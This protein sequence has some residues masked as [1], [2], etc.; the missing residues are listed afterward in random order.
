M[1]AP[2][3][4]TNGSATDLVKSI[5]ALTRV[6]QKRSET[7]H[8]IDLNVIPTAQCT[9]DFVIIIP[10]QYTSMMSNKCLPAFCHE[11]PTAQGNLQTENRAA[12][13]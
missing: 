2:V 9:Y 10:D 6:I 1:G 11:V 8:A 12:S 5:Q 3:F 7:D 13:R 4:K